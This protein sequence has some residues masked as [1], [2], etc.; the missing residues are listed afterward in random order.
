MLHVHGS[1]AAA[2][3]GRLALV[4]GLTAFVFVVELVGS[5]AT[6][7]LALL[8]DAGHLLTDVAGVGL[9]LLAI[10]FAGR[11]A[12]R[13]RTFGFLRLEIL[14]AVVNGVVLL[15][16]AV[17]VLVEAWRRLADPP[18]IATGAV[19]AIAVLGLAANGA[20]LVL[21]RGAQA[22]SLAMRGAYLEVL[23][24]LA[25]SAAVIVASIVVM[26]TDWRQADAVAS[27]FIAVLILPRTYRLLR[28]AVDVLLEATPRGIDLDDVRAHILDADGVADV[29]D[30]HAWTITSG[31]NVL[32]A[33]VVLEPGAEGAAVLDELCGCL[34]GDFDIEH[35]TFQL[36]TADRR[37]LEEA[38]H[39]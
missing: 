8:A 9:A 1:P 17:Y 39:R 36:E 30:L 29:H 35:S 24:D 20:S 22:R 4:L 34:S 23:G 33:H 19:L 27:A 13:E 5:F 6:G 18:A 37:R 28:E 10:Q 11:A 21:L 25:G 12:S 26:V 16:V 7:S 32:S 38:S 2:Y 3:R 31:V 14:A 15:G